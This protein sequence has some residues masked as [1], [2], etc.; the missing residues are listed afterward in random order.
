MHEY[1]IAMKGCSFSSKVDIPESLRLTA[2]GCILREVPARLPLPNAFENIFDLT[3]I[4]Y[5][6]SEVA[7]PI[8][9]GLPV[10]LVF[11]K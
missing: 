10:I 2:R 3:P 4:P 1:S 8:R 6:W 9:S 5:Q 7:V 11:T